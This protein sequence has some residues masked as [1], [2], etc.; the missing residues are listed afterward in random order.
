MILQAL[1]QHYEDLASKGKLSKP[2]WDKARVSYA[3]RI[4]QTG[5][6]LAIEDIR[7]QEEKGKKLVMSPA[8]M[9]LPQMVKRSSGVS[10]NFLCDN[11]SYML[12]LDIKSKDTDDESVVQKNRNRAIV[13]FEECRK[14][15]H[16]Y[17][18]EV[19]DTFAQAILAFFDQWRPEEAA[20]HPLLIDRKKD[21]AS[22][23]LIFQ[24]DLLFAQ[25][26][27]KITKAWDSKGNDNTQGKKGRCLVTGQQ[28]TIARLHPSIRGVRDANPT[29]A[30]L[31]SFN[32]RAFESY[33]CE[34]AQGFN[35]PI[36]EYT[37]FA[38]AA[39][40]NDLIADRDHCLHIGD[41]TVVFWAEHDSEAETD[42]FSSI[43]G[44]DNEI[45][46]EELKI[47]MQQVTKGMSAQWRG[48]TLQPDNQFFIL[49]LSPNSA[50]LSVRFFLQSKF[51]EL[52]ERI[53]RHHN[54][55][56]IIKPAYWKYDTLSLSN[57]LQE[58]VNPHATNKNAQP[59]LAGEVLRSILLD[60][61]YP[62]VL[63]QQ[64]ELRIRAGE[65]IT[66]GKAAI[67]KAYLIKN[68]L[69]QH[70]QYKEVTTVKLNEG[71]VYA[72]YVLGRLFSILEAVQETA[73]PGINTTI[74]DRYFNS[75]CCTPSIVFP[76]LIRLSQ[77]HLKK[78]GGGLAV[79]YQKQIQNLMG[80][81]T[82]SYPARLNLSDQGVFQ[83]GYYHQKQKRYEKKEAS[84]NE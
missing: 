70:P 26:V 75:A 21:L 60:I 69:T 27:Q 73:N 36:G 43:F 11:A 59:L 9:V 1:V 31:V 54:R 76:Q 38:Y 78:I 12:G 17:L 6:L 35:A 3:L 45:Q 58:T 72:P 81:L 44:I 49:A 77:S 22:A 48:C 8:I 40:L 74:R 46:D 7:L 82:E 39:A 16:F 68:Q 67:I 80:M 64:V 71:T 51:G 42:A 53:L 4:D 57:V 14:L 66:N 15:H 61:P 20:E 37:A 41:S 10:S 25:Q 50:R 79:N 62:E 55:M 56:E 32:A 63:Y 47:A 2:G 28:T 23:N 29:G 19:D 24:M 33:G 18:D 52:M 34:D 30:S 84:N 83:L 13:C 65:E 5:K